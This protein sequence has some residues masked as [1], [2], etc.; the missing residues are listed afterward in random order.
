MKKILLFSVI[1]VLIG[2]FEIKT[3]VITAEQIQN[4]TFYIHD[5][6]YHRQALEWI[7]SYILDNKN[8]L[9]VYPKEIQLI[10]NLVYL[11]FKRSLC[12]LQAQEAALKAMDTFW[13]GWQ[14]IA[15]TRMD[16]SITQPYY[17]PEH[18]KSYENITQF[19]QLH[20]KHRKIGLA[21]SHAVK[22]IVNGNSLITIYARD[23]VDTMRN[24]ART[25]VAHSLINVKN[26]VG[27][28]FYTEKKY[29][30]ILSYM[31][32]IWA[33]LP[34]L[35]LHSFVEANK[36]NDLVSKESWEIL[37]K[38]QNVGKYTWQIIEQD[39]AS[40][41]LAFYKAIW[42]Y[43][44]ELHLEQDYFKIL[45]DQDGPINFLPN[46]VSLDLHNYSSFS[47]ISR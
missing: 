1:L 29:Q 3:S 34:K 13:K 24:Q 38:I 14:N 44:K 43:M 25:V 22:N 6:P 33:Y 9:L 8:N 40:F 11:S 23:G 10:A 45:F 32:F 17:I 27:E 36:K 28:L 47:S 4:Q 16:P 41:Y 7:R 31:N 26:Y 30:K 42:H 18:D 12:T 35:A 39:R 21:Y 5:C 20:D 37:M 46:P 19:W 15:Q 2:P